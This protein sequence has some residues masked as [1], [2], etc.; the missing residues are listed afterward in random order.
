[1]NA[2]AE[3][4][5]HAYAKYNEL[6]YLRDKLKLS[7]AMTLT[8]VLL[9]SIAVG[10]VGRALLGATPRRPHQRLGCRYPRDC[11]GRL[12]DDAAGHEFR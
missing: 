3:S 1:M 2:L 10:R 6:D 7:F 4:V 8:L 5:E 9:S 12:H 11:G